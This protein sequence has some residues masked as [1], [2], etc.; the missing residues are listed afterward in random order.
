MASILGWFAIPS[1]SGSC[2]VRT[3]SAVTCPSW[4]ALCSMAHSFTEL[5]KPLLHNKAVIHEGES[6]SHS[7]VSNSAN[8]WTVAH[9]APLSRQEYWSGLP[10]LSLGYL[11]DPGIEPRFPAL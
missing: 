8:Q 5:Y 1:S 2:F 11:P 10:F 6:V 3:L 4:V 9:Q 7:V